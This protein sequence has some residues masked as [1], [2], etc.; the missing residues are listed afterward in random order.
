MTRPSY[1]KNDSLLAVHHCPNVDL[2]VE[3]F[4]QNSNE[5]YNGKMN[6]GQLTLQLA[7]SGG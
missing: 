5:C 6:T 7:A 3:M 4:A 1:L 2:D